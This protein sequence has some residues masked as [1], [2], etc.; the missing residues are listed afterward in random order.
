MLAGA[1]LLMKHFGWWPQ[2]LRLWIALGLLAAG[3]TMLAL[4]RRFP[5]WV[6]G[7]R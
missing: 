3:A 2:E 1:L 5:A 4:A 7:E 6:S